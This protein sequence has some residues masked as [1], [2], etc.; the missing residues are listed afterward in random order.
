[1]TL[2]PGTDLGPYRIIEP[3]GAGGMGEVYRARD[4]RIGRDVAVKVLPARFSQDPDRLRRF[5]QEARAAGALNHPNILVIYDVGTHE[6]A[7][8]VVA[9]L[10]QGETLRERLRGGPLPLRKAAEIGV[11]IAQGLASAHEHG[12][13]HRDLKPENLFVTRDGRVKILDFGLAKLTDRDPKEA[14][15]TASTLAADSSAG[16]AWG[17]V[18]YMSPEQARGLPLDH[19]SDIFTLGVIL[20]EMLSGRRPFQAATSAD[21]QSAILK[22]DPPDL[23]TLVPTVPPVLDRLVRHCLEKSPGERFQSARDFAFNLDA[24]AG[25]SGTQPV[26]VSGASRHSQL[27]LVAALLGLAIL[28]AL[29]IVPRLF[30]ASTPRGVLRASLDP[31]PGTIADVTSDCPA[32]SPDGR[33]V[34]YS[35]VD[36]IGG[37]SAL[38]L[39]H[40]DAPAPEKIPGTTGGFQPFWSPDSRSIGFFVPSK[41]ERIS[42]DGGPAIVLCDAGNPRGGSWGK[43]GVILFAPAATGGLLR[44]PASGGSPAPVTTLDSTRHEAA[45]RWPCFLPDGRR[46]LFLTVPARNG[47]Y[48]TF[49]GSLDSN[50]R[51]FVLQSDRGVQYVPPGYILSYQNDVLMAQRF[52]ANRLRPLG[53]ATGIAKAGSSSP[54]LGIPIGSASGNGILVFQG[55][56]TPNTELRWIDRTGQVTPIAGMPPGRYTTL[57]LSPGGDRAALVRVG[58]TSRSDLWTIDLGRRSAMRLTFDPGDEIDPVWSP[59]GTHLLYASDR[60]GGTDFLLKNLTGGGTDELVHRS[61]TWGQELLDWSRDGRHVLF[62]IS[63]PRSGADLWAL[64]LYGN[65]QAFPYVNSRFTE[66]MGK[67]SPDGKWVAYVSDESGAPEIYVQSFPKPDERQQVSTGT[68]VAP[69]WNRD[70]KEIVY[71]TIRGHIM[72]VPVREGPASIELGTPKQLFAWPPERFSLVKG[73]DLAPDG[74]F[75]STMETGDVT[76]PAPTLVVNWPE[77]LKG[78]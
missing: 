6:G 24:T 38:W 39:R 25:S 51:K 31:P 11:Q 62:Q 52:D 74:R 57:A 4:G 61:E 46:F 29:L 28:G 64:P 60:S 14:R 49:V 56:P 18:G 67:F 20:F 9:E 58:G 70:G 23:T 22:E 78:K 32:I 45:H 36:S 27:P 53:Q 72:S 44:V 68:G 13:V 7:P 50:H 77:L 37:M 33:M 66:V 47:S 12:I 3:I 41:L 26:S 16:G 55:R 2:N 43:N 35:R 10:L 59:D 5:E 48:D 76:P 40:L 21:T 42:V 30:R 8:Y 34:V 19:R 17:T 65:R 71:G 63:N 54:A 1:M 69:F 75:L 15:P 73:L